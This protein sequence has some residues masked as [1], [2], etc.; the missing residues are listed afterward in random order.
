MTVMPARRK[1]ILL[2]AAFL[3]AL[4]VMRRESSSHLEAGDPLPAGRV[5]SDGFFVSAALF[6][7][8][9]ILSLVA[10]W[11]GFDTMAYGASFLAARFTR[12]EV[13]H[14]S[15]FDY[16]RAKREEREGRKARGGGS[17]PPDI[18]ITGLVMLAL[19]VAAML[20]Q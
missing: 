6:L 5:W 9:G 17:L 14:K 16:V 11:G 10:S 1:L 19:S 12:R 18:I 3:V 8:A 15:Y 2:L 13:G 7:S 4:L 20:A